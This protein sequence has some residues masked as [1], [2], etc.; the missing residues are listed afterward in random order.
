MSIGERIQKIIPN[1]GQSALARAIGVSQSTLNNWLVRGSDIPAQ[2][3]PSIA[4]H[5]GVTIQF[6]LTGESENSVSVGD[7]SEDEK[8]LVELYRGLDKAGKRYLM[9]EAEQEHRRANA[10]KGTGDEHVG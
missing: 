4:S 7:L 3:I 9:G 6:L 8:D 1:R 10:K 2:Y 5:L